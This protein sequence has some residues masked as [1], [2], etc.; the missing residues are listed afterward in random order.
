MIKTIQAKFEAEVKG[1]AD[2]K[3]DVRSRYR[4]LLAAGAS[5][6]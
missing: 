5:S 2:H 1:S 4:A 3:K 6:T